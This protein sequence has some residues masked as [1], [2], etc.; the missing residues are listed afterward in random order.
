MSLGIII[1][2]EHLIL[3]TLNLAILR[4]L[5]LPYFKH[6]NILALILFLIIFFTIN[7]IL[8]IFTR[9]DIENIQIL[10]I[11]VKDKNLPKIANKALNLFKRFLRS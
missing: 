9:I 10:L 1:L 2:L 11:K 6:L 4:Y 7:V 5:N 8:K 3:D